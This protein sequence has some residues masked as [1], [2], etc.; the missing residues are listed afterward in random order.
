M[1]FP[2]GRGGSVERGSPRLQLRAPVCQCRILGTTRNISTE[3]VAAR[4]FS[5]P[6]RYPLV[7]MFP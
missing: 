2:S 5:H 6:N 1:V 3:R 7:R 4:P